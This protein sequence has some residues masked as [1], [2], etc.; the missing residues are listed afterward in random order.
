[1]QVNDGGWVLLTCPVHPR[2]ALQICLYGHYWTPINN[3]V[4]R[5]ERDPM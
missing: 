3:R 1:L 2:I 4:G 5:M